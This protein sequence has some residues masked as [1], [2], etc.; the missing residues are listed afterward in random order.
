MYS[1]YF[2]LEC[3]NLFSGVNWSISSFCFISF[4]IPEHTPELVKCYLTQLSCLTAVLCLSTSPQGHHDTLSLTQVPGSSDSVQ[5]NNPGLSAAT[6]SNDTPS[7][8]THTLIAPLNLSRSKFS[9]LQIKGQRSQTSNA[10]K[11]F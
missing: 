6:T 8:D 7:L 1:C 10:I 4:D 2:I 3:Y 11:N 5:R 9:D